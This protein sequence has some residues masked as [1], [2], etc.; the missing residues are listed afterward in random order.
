MSNMYP[1]S[2]ALIC[3][4]NGEKYIKQQIDSIY[5]ANDNFEI[6]VY[7]FDSQD[8]TLS[9]CEEYSLQKNLTV[10]S[11][12]FAPGAK[13]SFMFA[14]NEFKK[15]YHYNY[16]DYLLFLSDQ[17]DIWKRNK[18][19]EVSNLHYEIDNDLPQFV[20]HNVQLVNDFGNKIYRSFYDY[21]ESII[22]QRYSPFYFSVVIGH[23]ISM[24]KKFVE[25]LTCFDGED[26]IMHDWWLSIIADINNCRYY[27]NNKLGYYRIHSDNIYGLNYSG[28]NVLKKLQNYFSNC[29]AINKQRLKILTE[30]KHK[31]QFLS[32]FKILLLNFRYK[33]LLLV[34]G[35]KILKINE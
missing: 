10:Y 9:I 24:N 15:I 29:E 27:I 8:N 21:P 32:I 34:L 33:L 4:H 5:I 1:K 22:T 20:H 13:N 26:I 16:E 35:Q 19:F 31:D 18:F 28:Y 12:N 30:F 2:F 3:S 11:Y 23:T 17:D 7:D 6:L 25:L 14:L